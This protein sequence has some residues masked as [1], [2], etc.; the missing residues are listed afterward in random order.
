MIPL[1]PL[2]GFPQD[3]FAALRAAV[4]RAL[5]Q[6]RDAP[7]GCLARSETTMARR[8]GTTSSPWLSVVMP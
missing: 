1:G 2:D 8:P 5:G 3:V 4:F 7:Q 6:G